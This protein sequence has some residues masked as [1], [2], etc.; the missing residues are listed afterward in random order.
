MIESAYAAKKYLEAAKTV[1]SE[2]ELKNISLLI[3]IETKTGFEKREEIFFS[4]SFE[5]LDGVVFGRTDMTESLE[6]LVWEN[7]SL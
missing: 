1:F 3:N 4:K 6:L 5:E 7:L 2:E